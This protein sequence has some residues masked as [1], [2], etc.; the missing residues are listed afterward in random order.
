M[1]EN[2]SSVPTAVYGA[3]LLMASIAYYVMVR[4][5]LRVEGPESQLAA[6]VGNDVKGRIST[7]LYIA[8]LPLAFVH[9]AIA[10]VVYVTVALIWLIPDRRIESRIS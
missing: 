7:A 1:G 2:H 5:M 6:A 3:V 8:A 10:D 4:L 9:K